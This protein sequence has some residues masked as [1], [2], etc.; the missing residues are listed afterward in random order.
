ME[1]SGANWFVFLESTNQCALA[2]LYGHN[3]KKA[4]TSLVVTISHLWWPCGSSLLVPLVDFF[5][6][7]PFANSLIHASRSKK[8]SC[9]ICASI[10][11]RKYEISCITYEIFIGK[12]IM[13]QR[14][15]STIIYSPEHNYQ[16]LNQ[17]LYC[18]HV[19]ADDNMQFKN[20]IFKFR[21]PFTSQNSNSSEIVKLQL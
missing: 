3:C 14:L 6:H 8:M 11:L 2:S 15:E 1:P 12:S 7:I 4:M 21:R 13:L 9:K 5:R 17:T 19:S 16:S 10:Y 18:E 20:D